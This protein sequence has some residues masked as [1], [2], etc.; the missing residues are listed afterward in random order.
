MRTPYR[1]IT[2][3]HS[4]SSN[5]LASAMYPMISSITRRELGPGAEH[6]PWFE[7]E[8]SIAGLEA[9]LD[10]RRTPRPVDLLFLTDHMSA[11]RH[12]IA[13]ETL[14]FACHCPRFAVGGEV[15]TSVPNG[16][17]G[18][19]DAPEVLVYGT[20]GPHARGG[21]QY[22]GMT[23]AL[24]DELFETC[25]RPGAPAPDPLKVHAFCASRGIACAVAHALDGHDLPLPHVLGLIGSFD[26]IE[27]LNGGYPDESALLLERLLEAR[28][29]ENR[30]TLESRR[31][32][33]I[34]RQLEVPAALALG[35]SD[36]H[37]DDFDRVVTIFRHDGGQPDAG[38]FVRAMLTARSDPS[39]ARDT[40]AVEGHG[41][42]TLTLHR[43]VFTLILRNVRRLR[44]H[45]N[46]MWQVLRLVGRG[47]VSANG[48]LRRLDRA[49]RALRKDLIAWLDA[50]ERG[51]APAAWPLSASPEG[52]PAA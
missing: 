8:T 23:Q 50:D 35:G 38:D 44:P 39:G 22:Y 46:G 1:V 25:T 30:R 41:M 2:H 52:D 47:A 19:L 26:F 33:P 11:R 40:F 15:Q 5:D 43:E 20:A 34:G 36:A 49:S 37:L 13:E 27:T 48:E 7:C 24:L 17:G 14:D 16:A 4:T 28:R 32:R 9:I 10:G 18:W 3:I 45:F 42:R 6:L 29:R 12:V 31:D 51:T 21:G